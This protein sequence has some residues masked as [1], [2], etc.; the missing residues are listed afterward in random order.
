MLIDAVLSSTAHTVVKLVTCPSLPA[1][2]LNQTKEN[3]SDKKTSILASTFTKLSD[4]LTDND[5]ESIQNAN[6]NVVVVV[7]DIDSASGVRQ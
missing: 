4:N 6:S 7:V 2:T 3:N 5:G 1:C